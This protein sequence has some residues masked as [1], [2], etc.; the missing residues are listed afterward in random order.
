M[1][2]V[3]QKALPEIEGSDR[4]DGGVHV[5]T[6]EAVFGMALGRVDVQ[7]AVPVDQDPNRSTLRGHTTVLVSG[8]EKS[9]SVVVF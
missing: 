9:C 4:V 2:W 5:Q 8:P 1:S 6:D 7:I 3:K